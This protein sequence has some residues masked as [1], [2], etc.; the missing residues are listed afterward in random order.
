VLEREEKELDL[1][2]EKL[3]RADELKEAIM[4]DIVDD[5][6]D[7]VELEGEELLP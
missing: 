1:D 2:D 3:E 4:E 6:N 7:D 5:F